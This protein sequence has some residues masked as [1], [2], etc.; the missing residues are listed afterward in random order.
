MI[1][2]DIFISLLEVV[3]SHERKSN[4]GRPPFDVLMMFKVLILKN[5]YNLSDDQFEFQI[6]DRRT[7]LMFLGITSVDRIPD[8]K[9][10]WLFGEQLSQL[11]L[12]EKLFQ[13]FNDELKRQGV[14]IKGGIAIDG[15]FV[16][17]PK[18]HFTKDDYEQIKKGEKPA[19]RTIKKSIESQ[20]DF[21]ARYTKLGLQYEQ[22]DKYKSK[23]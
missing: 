10:I 8:S 12:A 22:I 19:S 11:G 6:R 7:F 4:A 16:D 15:T 2:W 3:R 14:L 13:R 1:N 20:T 5:I 9:T 17:V 23:K 18:Q 21:D